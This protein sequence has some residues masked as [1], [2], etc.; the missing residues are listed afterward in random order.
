MT[1]ADIAKHVS[2]DESSYKEDISSTKGKYGSCVYTWESDRPEKEITSKVTGSVFKRP[3]KNQ[4]TIKMLDFYEDS[5]LKLYEQDAAIDLFDQS[6]KKLSQA[7]H[8]KLLANMKKKLAN[9]PDGFEK[10]KKMMDAR[11]KFTA[12]G[13]EAWVDGL[14]M[15]NGSQHADTTLLVD[16]AV[17]HCESRELFKTVLDDEARGVFQGKIIVEPG[18]SLDYFTGVQWWR[19]ERLTAAVI[20][21]E[22]EP[23]ISTY[24]AGD[25]APAGALKPSRPSRATAAAAPA[26]RR[27][28]RSSR[29]CSRSAGSPCTRSSARRPGSRG[30]GARSRWDRCGSC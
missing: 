25:G 12:E 24:A 28:R 9:N 23:I 10:A 30:S 21:A 3:D 1:K 16:H 6:Y 14:Y 20:P 17:P 27:G 22:G 2:I 11:M 26:P 15:L 7:E 4:V 19:S 13:G 8:D 5:D 29:R 18:A